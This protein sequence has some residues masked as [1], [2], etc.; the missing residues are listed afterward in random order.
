MKFPKNELTND[1]IAKSISLNSLMVKITKYYLCNLGA[2]V[3]CFHFS[4]N[5]CSCEK[6]VVC[7]ISLNFNML[8]YL[9]CYDG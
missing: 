3:F 2:C 8:R 6:V 7:K 1:L 5:R 4:D 9:V